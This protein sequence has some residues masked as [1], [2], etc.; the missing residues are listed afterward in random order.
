MR[1]IA[2]NY[3]LDSFS[4][5]ALII[6]LKSVRK[7]QKNTFMQLDEMVKISSP[8]EKWSR[9]RIIALAKE[10]KNLQ[11]GIEFQITKDVNQVS[12]VVGEKS[13]AEYND[14]LS[15]NQ[16][17]PGFNNLQLTNE[18]LQSMVEVI[19][20]EK[21]L[22]EIVE[23]TFNHHIVGKMEN[24]LRAGIL[25]GASYPK[26]VDALKD[27]YKGLEHR[28]V[29][30]VRT[31]VQT[32]NNKAFHTV[33]MANQDILQP[34]FEWCAILDNRACIRCMCL[35]G[36]KFRWDNSG[37]PAPPIHP[38]CRCIR[39]SITMP[40]GEITG[41]KVDIPEF[42]ESL[43]NWVLRDGQVG[44]GGAKIKAYG[45]I[46]GNYED[47]FNT[48]SYKK[49]IHLV[50]PTRAELLKQGKINFKDMIDSRGNV[51]LLRDDGEGLKK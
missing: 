3:R 41:G 40:W 9:E 30:L 48:L 42:E 14:I 51:R 16:T 7:A 4:D 33:A 26:I 34:E 43:R 11:A 21:I 32:V 35:D 22:D 47:F 25:E 24:D 46:K 38:R 36:R 10:L 45:Q 23:E 6:M 19:I 1:Q 12:S 28:I 31:Q 50:G 8:V 20:K 37:A 27:N 2:W 29:T 17:V 15:V 5:S 39:K 44:V 18:Q 49:Q 13:I